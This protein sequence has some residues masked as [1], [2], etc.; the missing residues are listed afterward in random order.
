MH[1]AAFGE[2]MSFCE[3]MYVF[4]LNLSLGMKLLAYE[5]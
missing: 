5:V 3:H 4:L 2:Y 1:S